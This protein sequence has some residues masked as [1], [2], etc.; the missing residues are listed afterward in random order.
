MQNKLDKPM[1]LKF[2]LLVLYFVVKIVIYY[3]KRYDVCE[4][5]NQKLISGLFNFTVNRP[6][7]QGA[8]WYSVWPS[9]GWGY[10]KQRI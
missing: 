1:Y 8:I 2:T 9:M 5:G 7:Y 6:K 4:I 10:V 3:L